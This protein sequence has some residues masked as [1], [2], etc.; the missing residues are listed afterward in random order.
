LRRVVKNLGIDYMR[1]LPNFIRDRRT[2]AQIEADGSTAP[3]HRHWRSL[4]AITTGMA[5]ACAPVEAKTQAALMLDFLDS[6]ISQRRIYAV[7]LAD[8]GVS[9]TEIAT[10]LG[11]DSTRDVT[12]I[13]ERTR[14]RRKFRT[15]LELWSHGYANH[16]I[17]QRLDLA[18]P[19][20][21]ERVIKAA[22]EILRRYYRA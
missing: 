10:T 1:G 8:A 15:A 17:A 14:E 7:E 11:L 12:R 22:K 20:D 16:H 19:A 5:P 18:T 13:L 2:R 6:S 3:A 9:L 4:T 21:A